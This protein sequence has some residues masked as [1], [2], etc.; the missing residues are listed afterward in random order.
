MIL[1]FI[2]RLFIHS[3]LNSLSARIAS[4]RQNIDMVLADLINP[5]ISSDTR[6]DLQSDLAELRYELDCFIEEKK[7]IEEQLSG[8]SESGS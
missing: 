2:R 1:S 3:R 5:D 6:A 7:E 8:R 4:H